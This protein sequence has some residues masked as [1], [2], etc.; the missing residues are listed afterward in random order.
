MSTRLWDRSRVE[1]KI[2]RLENSLRF[3]E[4]QAA[5]Q[6]HVCYQWGSISTSDTPD[7]DPPGFRSPAGSITTN[8][9][10]YAFVKCGGFVSQCWIADWQPRS[11]MAKFDQFHVFP[12]PMTG[13]VVVVAQTKPGVTVRMQFEVLALKQYYR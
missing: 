4:Q 2:E 1:G 10:E 8:K 6:M 11:E 13:E 5:T 9:F 7:F 12:D 3:V